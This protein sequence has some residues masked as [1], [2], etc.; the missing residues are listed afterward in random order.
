MPVVVAGE[1]EDALARD[2]ER[3]VEVIRQLEQ[4][5]AGVGCL[6]PPGTVVGASHV[7]ARPYPLLG[8]PVPHPVAIQAHRN[9]GRLVGGRLCPEPGSA[10][11]KQRPKDKNRC[12]TGR[13]PTGRS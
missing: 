4:E 7:G 6:I 13:S 8:P 1:I 12:C 9:N 10:C 2:I 3:H 5:M 11:Q